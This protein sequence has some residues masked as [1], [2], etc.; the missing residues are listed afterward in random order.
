M[1]ATILII[2]E[3]RRKTLSP[4][5][6][7]LVCVNTVLLGWTCSYR[8]RMSFSLQGSLPLFSSQLIPFCLLMYRRAILSNGDSAEFFLSEGMPLLIFL[9]S[10]WPRRNICYCFQGLWLRDENLLPGV[11]PTV[12]MRKYLPSFYLPFQFVCQ[13]HV[14][15][16]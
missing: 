4:P 2:P 5:R 1:S 10:Y 14:S 11:S 15:L 12:E 3:M 16:W 8:K 6:W 7:N 9:R 13:G